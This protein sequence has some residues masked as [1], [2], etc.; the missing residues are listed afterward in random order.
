MKKKTI[1]S[2]LGTLLLFI[3]FTQSDSGGVTRYLLIYMPVLVI[4]L[5]A[6]VLLAGKKAPGNRKYLII[7]A[8]FISMALFSS[9][10]FSSL[11][12]F[13][14]LTMILVALPA[15]Y[16]AMIPDY[17]RYAM[18]LNIVIY[19]SELLFVGV[20]G[21]NFD[22]TI[23]NALGAGREG[24]TETWGFARYSAHHTEPGA[25]AA[26]LAC[27]CMLSLQGDRKP[28]MLHWTAWLVL[29]SLFSFTAMILG[30]LVLLALLLAAGKTWK[31]IAAAIY[32]PALAF[33]AI[34]ALLPL[35][36]INVVDYFTFRMIENDMQDGSVGVKLM[37][38][39]DVVSRGVVTSIAGN[40]FEA[41]YH[42]GY[43]RSLG[44][45]FHL[46]F[47]GGLFGLL[48]IVGILW[49]AFKRLGLLGLFLAIVLLLS[50]LPI[51][52]AQILF[53]LLV[54]INLPKKKR[55]SSIAKYSFDSEISRQE[56][57]RPV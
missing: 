31:S 40:R 28:T 33:V 23:F 44:F 19:V 51:D 18:T 22:P 43:S 16:V 26:N 9:N 5:G 1:S 21:Q 11:T 35:I 38:L 29:L 53:V 36:G 49:T 37:L 34:A 42:C 45:G 17:A 39:E 52:Q 4:L 6:I 3:T 47:Q 20:L 7:F 32:G 41:C 30:E 15:G 13:I 27:L 8:F 24:L 50:R 57:H 14:A 55:R 46:L 48:V 25:F 2:G 56:S 10:S 12:A 54:I